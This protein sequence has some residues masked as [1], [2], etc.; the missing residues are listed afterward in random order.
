[1]RE[2]DLTLSQL[3]Y[4][5]K[6]DYHLPNTKEC[7]QLYASCAKHNHPSTGYVNCYVVLYYKVRTVLYVAL[8]CFVSVQTLT[9]QR[10][11]GIKWRFMECIWPTNT[12][13]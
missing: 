7:V 3:Y 2:W 4:E 13:L 11:F 6:H 12:I 1:M 9:P 10:K 5:V 8:L